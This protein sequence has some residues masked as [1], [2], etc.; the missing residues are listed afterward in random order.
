MKATAPRRWAFFLKFDEIV[1][2]SSAVWR[3]PQRV[4]LSSVRFAVQRTIE[5]LATR[6]R[7]SFLHAYAQS[8]RTSAS[9]SL[10]LLQI[11]GKCHDGLAAGRRCACMGGTTMQK[12]GM[13]PHVQWLA[14][15]RNDSEKGTAQEGR[16]LGR[17]TRHCCGIS[18][19]EDRVRA[20]GDSCKNNVG[21]WDED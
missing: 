8:N 1:F 11:P 2:A 17:A 6:S 10:M 18:S 9:G 13:V 16:D 15:G 20:R 7:K 5:L 3:S 14:I 21:G 12:Q 19:G 4:V